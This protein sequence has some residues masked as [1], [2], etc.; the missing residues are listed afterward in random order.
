[1]PLQ[2]SKP[3][4]IKKNEKLVIGHAGALHPDAITIDID[5]EHKPDVIHDLHEC[6]WPFADNQFKEIICHHVL[7][8]L[9]DLSDPMKELHRICRSDGRI[10]IDVPHHSSWCAKSPDHKLYFSYFGFDGYLASEK[11]WRTG[12]KFRLLSRQVTFHRAFRRWG[13]NKLFNRYPMAYERFWT[14]IFPAEHLQLWIQP[15]K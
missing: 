7:E 4:E 8:H 13:F 3:S 1:M 14:Y 12:K 6:P 15:V 11:T 10:Y 5:P 2:Q 9:N